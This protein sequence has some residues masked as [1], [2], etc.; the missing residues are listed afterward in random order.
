MMKVNAFMPVLMCSALLVACG[1]DNKKDEEPATTDTVKEFTAVAAKG[2]LLK[3]TVNESKKTYRYEVIDS[4]FGLN[5]KTGGGTYKVADDGALTVSDSPNSKMYLLPNGLVLGAVTEEFTYAGIK[6]RQTTPF[7]GIQNPVEDLATGAGKYN[8]IGQF[9][10][11][12]SSICTDYGTFQ[13]KA[14]ATWVKCDREDKSD[15]ADCNKR[16]TGTMEHLGDGRWQLMRSGRHIG[17]ALMFKSGEQKVSLIDL[18]DYSAAGLGTGIIFASSQQPITDSDNIGT[19]FYNDDSGRGGI[20][21]VEKGFYTLNKD[22]HKNKYTFTN[23]DPWNGMQT[24]PAKERSIFTG[25]GVFV[26]ELNGS[27]LFGIKK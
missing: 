18:R 10:G 5:G 1:S 22:D 2:E 20:A 26:S 6:A 12:K 3:Y 11:H 21:K 8:Y 7:L 25:A 24:S 14:D 27:L 17:T 4:A 13:I 23:N 9:C 19:W 15:A 16:E